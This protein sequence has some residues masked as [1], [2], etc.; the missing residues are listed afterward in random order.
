MV[1]TAQ[2]H[3]NRSHSYLQFTLIST[4]VSYHSY[5]ESSLHFPMYLRRYVICTVLVRGK[6][7]QLTNY[8]DFVVNLTKVDGVRSPRSAIKNS[9]VTGNDYISGRGGFIRGLQNLRTKRLFDKLLSLLL[10]SF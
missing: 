6:V 5:S 4:C 10:Q 3:S 2:S 7:H 8:K 1:P 9:T